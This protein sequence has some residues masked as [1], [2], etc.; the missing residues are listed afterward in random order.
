MTKSY[1][2]RKSL[3]NQATVHHRVRPKEELKQGRNL[4]SETE[5]ETIEESF[6]LDFSS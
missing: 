6:I 2:N 1:L 4:E 5:E 3:H